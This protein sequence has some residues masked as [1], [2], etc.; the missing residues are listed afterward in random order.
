MCVCR[1]S[2]ERDADFHEII[3][4]NFVVDAV[5]TTHVMYRTTNACDSFSQLRNTPAGLYRDPAKMVICYSLVLYFF[6]GTRLPH[7]KQQFFL[8]LFV[9]S[10]RRF[11]G[12]GMSMVW[13]GDFSQL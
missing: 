11:F 13:L 4:I 2:N 8:M 7:L 3:S 6:H 9:N 10:C 5:S 1:V 12:C